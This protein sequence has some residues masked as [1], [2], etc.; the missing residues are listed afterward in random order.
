MMRRSTVTQALHNKIN[1]SGAT[2]PSTIDRRDTK[3]TQDFFTEKSLSL[4]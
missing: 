4:G 1:G 2:M 3:L